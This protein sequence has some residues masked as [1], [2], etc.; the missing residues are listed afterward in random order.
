MTPEEEQRAVI[1]PTKLAKARYDALREIAAREGTD[2]AALI[3][4][5]ADLLI[6]SRGAP[7][8]EKA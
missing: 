5:G 2:V 3:E 8:G 7:A 6:E 4:E 1:L